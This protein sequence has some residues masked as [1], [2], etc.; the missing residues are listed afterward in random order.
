MSHVLVHSLRD[1]CS[2]GLQHAPD[3][4]VRVVASVRPAL[5]E[6]HDPVQRRHG[7]RGFRQHSRR[8][9]MLVIE[10]RR[11]QLHVETTPPGSLPPLLP[12]SSLVAFDRDSNCLGPLCRD[13]S[14]WPRPARF[15]FLPYSYSYC[16][17]TSTYGTLRTRTRTRGVR[18]QMTAGLHQALPAAEQES[19]HQ[20]TELSFARVRACIGGKAGVLLLLQRT[21]CYA[22]WT[23]GLL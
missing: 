15:E 4:Y 19:F 6:G 8:N 14:A 10:F 20:A 1:L 22:V 17:G 5:Q 23:L 7:C 18:L 3:G 2:H 13:L 9:K 12:P 16:T 21:C 11:T